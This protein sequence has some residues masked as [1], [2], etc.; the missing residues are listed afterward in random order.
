MLS[1]IRVYQLLT[2][3]DQAAHGV[4]VSA[5]DEKS[6][7]PAC[8]RELE[9]KRLR[10]T[11]VI[12]GGASGLD[13]GQKT[14]LDSLFRLVLAPLAEE[15]Q[16][17]VVDGGTDAGIM[18]L[19]GQARTQ[20]SGTFSLVGVAPRSLVNLP[21]Y[22]VTHPDASTL[23]PHH[24]HCILV[25]GKNWGDESAWMAEI[26]TQLSGTQG[27]MTILINGGSV[28]WQDAYASVKVGREVVIIAGSGRTADVMVKALQGNTVEDPR[29]PRLLTSGLLSSVDLENPPMEL[30]ETI[31][32]LLL[33]QAS[34]P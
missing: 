11:L 9:L 18:G 8:L 19:M 22:R 20:I 21:D 31:K 27:S 5:V 10:P 25:P 16:L 14:Q 28:T 15:L 2:A 6:D 1:P 29:M 4:K 33:E 23:E 34:T 17:H 3:K 7:I 13:N 32:A 24:S 30:K 26:A 12:V